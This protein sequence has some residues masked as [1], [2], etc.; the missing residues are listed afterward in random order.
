MRDAEGVGPRHVAD[1]Q[2]GER[3]YR[4]ADEVWKSP[5]HT[6]KFRVWTRTLERFSVY[7]MEAESQRI[8]KNMRG[9]RDGSG[10]TDV[11]QP[12]S[13]WLIIEGSLSGRRVRCL[14]RYRALSLHES[15]FLQ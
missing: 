7:R 15:R 14:L 5:I 4:D 11:R 2:T 3:R 13:A 9:L 1:N 6:G 10:I 8:G 12:P